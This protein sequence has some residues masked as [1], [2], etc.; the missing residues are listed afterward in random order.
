MRAKSFLCL[1]LSLLTIIVWVHLLWAADTDSA[2]PSAWLSLGGDFQRTGLSQASGPLQ[3]GLWWE[4]ETDGAVL[5]SVTVGSDSRI[6]VACEDGKLYTLALDGQSL[7]IADVNTPLT[8]APTIGPDGGL[9]V[10]GQDGR[11]FAF[12]SNG[13]LRWTCQTGDTIYS[14]PAVAPDGSVYVGSTDGIL[15]ALDPNGTELW[16]FTTKGVGVLPAGAIFASPALAADGTVYV[17]GLYDPNL[18]A[19]HPADGSLKWACRLS[20]D[21]QDPTDSGWPFA[22]PVV[23]PD[24]TIYQT[25]VYDPH[26]YAIDPN[27]GVIRWSVDLCD[28]GV[29]GEDVELDGNVWSEPVLGPDGTIYVSCDDPYLRAVD[30]NGTI[31][32]TQ[33][34]GETGGFTMTVDKNG[35]IYAASDDG[36]VYVAAP[37][38]AP[39]AQFE[40]GGWP[41]FPVIAAD[42]LLLLGDSKD[43]SAFAA[44]TPNAVWAI[45]ALAPQP[46]EDANL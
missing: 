35:T 16:R 37:D 2:I 17:A 6:H 34:F 21:T 14:S 7:W 5:S 4:F 44:P 26:L 12:D 13:N 40:T 27:T 18:Y 42:G 25:L 15:Y 3:G 43:Y 23:A 33:P 38:G 22:S 1:G 36:F 24:G 41:A 29:F 11:L 31:K 9:Y 39:V 32:W 20:Q 45:S 30:P 10:G 46:V 19:F 8:S 28:P